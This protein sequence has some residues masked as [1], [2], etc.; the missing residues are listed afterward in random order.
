MLVLNQHEICC[1]NTHYFVNT[2]AVVGGVVSYTK[3]NEVSSQLVNVA[4]CVF[5]STGDDAFRAQKPSFRS[6]PRA[7]VLIRVIPL[8]LLVK[9][10]KTV[11]GHK[12]RIQKEL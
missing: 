12:G 8:Q 2:S 4:T 1:L 9:G 7:G 10:M 6:E 11:R 3:G 5:G